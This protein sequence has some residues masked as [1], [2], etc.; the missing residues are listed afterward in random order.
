MDPMG[1][2]EC[3]DCQDRP[4]LPQL[5]IHSDLAEKMQL[6]SPLLQVDKTEI[7]LYLTNKSSV[8]D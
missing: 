8:P 5:Q 1:T 6:L 7:V 4:Q 2:A 3:P